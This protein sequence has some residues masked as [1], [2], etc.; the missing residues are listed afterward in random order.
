MEKNSSTST[1]NL[2][3]CILNIVDLLVDQRN[4]EAL[5]LVHKATAAMI[6]QGTKDDRVSFIEIG[7]YIDEACDALMKGMKSDEIN[8]LSIRRLIGNL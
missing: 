5:Q 1:Q 8:S 4:I 3:I 2:G 7:E 6:M